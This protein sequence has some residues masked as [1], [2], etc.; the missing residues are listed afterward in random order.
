MVVVGHRCPAYLALVSDWTKLHSIGF[1]GACFQDVDSSIYTALKTVSMHISMLVDAKGLSL[2]LCCF[3][4]P[5][6]Q[7]EG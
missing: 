1:P 3:E 2:L 6:L 5:E 4:L 7:K